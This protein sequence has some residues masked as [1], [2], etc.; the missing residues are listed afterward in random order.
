MLLATSSSIDGIAKLINKYFHSDA[1]TVLPSL[2]ITHPRINITPDFC[3]TK[4]KARYR[5]ESIEA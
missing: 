5:F 4:S 3:V 2:E 1:Y